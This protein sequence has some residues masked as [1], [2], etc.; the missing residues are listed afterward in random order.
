M[1]I[2]PEHASL[3]DYEYINADTADGIRRQCAQLYFGAGVIKLIGEG[4]DTH[5]SVEEIRAAVDE[6]HSAGFR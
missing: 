6:A 1:G 2:P 4:I 5:Y 3:F